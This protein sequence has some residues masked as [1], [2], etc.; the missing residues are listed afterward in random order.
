MKRPL[1]SKIPE[2]KNDEEIA[3]FM[4]KYSPFDLVDAGLAEIVPT[5]FFVRARNGE[6][7]L[8]KD[9][10]VQVAFKDERSIR[11]AFSSL[12]SSARIFFV[13]DADP[14]GI[15][16]GLLDDP[17]SENFYVPYLNISGIKILDGSKKKA[18]RV[19]K[20]KRA[21]DLRMQNF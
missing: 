4:E 10:H 15:L 16:L 6:K 21:S 8:L 13:I 14:A 9:K 5:P 20:N 12:I 3:A 19:K 18:A 7:T 11:K 17:A 2:F 1:P